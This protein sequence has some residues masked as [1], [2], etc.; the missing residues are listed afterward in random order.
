MITYPH[1]GPITATHSSNMYSMHM[2]GMHNRF[3][4]MYTYSSAN[5]ATGSSNYSGNEFAFTSAAHLI[6][7][8]IL[9]L[10][11]TLSSTKNSRKMNLL[12]IGSTHDS[13]SNSSSSGNSVD[14]G[15]ET[16]LVSQSF[17]GTHYLQAY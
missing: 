8:P 10:L 16:L 3:G 6:V 17:A 7:F 12:A 2:Y 15:I 14:T 11:Q 1:L 4:G 13:S 5:Y 9:K